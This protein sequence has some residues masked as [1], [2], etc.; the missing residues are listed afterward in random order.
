MNIVE[1]NKAPLYDAPGHQGMVMRRLQGK[2]AGPSQ[3]AWIG[4]S[5]I[6]PGGGTT[7]SASDVEKF[8]VVLSGELTVVAR[9]GSLIQEV[10]LRPLDSCRIEPEEAR[11]L[12]NQTSS[13]VTV[14]LV[15]PNKA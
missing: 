11:Q 1:H 7:S 12:I 2:E 15:M 4:L 13:P 8:Y 3:S 6:E 10:K 9:R 5:V 14:L